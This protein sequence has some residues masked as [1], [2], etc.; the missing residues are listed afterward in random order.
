MGAGRFAPSPSGDLHVGN[1]RTAILAWLFARSSSRGF[2]LRIEDLDRARAGAEAGQLHDLA[3]IGLDWDGDVV[4]QSERLDLFD[5]AIGQLRARG[6]LYECFCTRRD[7]AEAAS[8]PHAAPGAYPGTC[9]T[10]D[11]ARRA[12]KREVRPAAWRLLTEPTEFTITDLLHGEYTGAV[13]DFVVLRNDGV[14]A[15]NLAVVVD[16]AAQG[17]DQ[18]VRGDDLLSSAPRQ[19]YLASLLGHR[20]PEYAHVPLALNA[21]GARLA[22]RDGAVTLAQLALAGT[23]AA[24]VR[25]QILDSLNL[26]TSSLP[27]ALAAFDPAALPRAPWIHS[28]APSGR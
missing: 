17:I 16:D 5:D 27:A 7:I 13:D 14:P 18:V 20:A 26:P 21:A 23:S 3:A 1:L 10:L 9:R 19:A 4:R 22:K 15:Y 2:L 25:A 11:E 6:L 8:A 24:Q 12:A 28:A